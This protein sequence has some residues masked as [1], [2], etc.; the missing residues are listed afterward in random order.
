MTQ[1]QIKAREL[2]AVKQKVLSDLAKDISSGKLR[3][4]AYVYSPAGM[5]KTHALKSSLEESGVYFKYINGAMSMP[6]F[7]VELATL[8]YL[9]QDEKEILILVD[10]CDS[11]FLEVQFAD[12]VKGI[13]ERKN[14]TLQ[15]NKYGKGWIN[16]L[17]EV[18]REAVKFHSNSSTMGFTVP[19]GRFRFCFLSNIQ[20]PFKTVKRKPNVGRAF[21]LELHRS[22]IRSRCRTIDIDLSND[23]LWGWVANAVLDSRAII[24]DLG[25]EHYESKA[26]EILDWLW[27]HRSQLKEFS[28]RT[29]QKMAEILAEGGDSDNWEEEFILDESV[30]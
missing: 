15:Y 28:I 5:G 17:S 29:S 18:Q 13:L 7:A 20:L 27:T 11:M 26:K 25:E 3:R 9:N 30:E 12:T 14:P 24:D 1:K 22:A 23:V 10:D 6:Y 16:T 4:H 21:E 8:N 2:A 19:T